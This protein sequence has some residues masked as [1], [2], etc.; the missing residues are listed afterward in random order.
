MPSGK[1]RRARGSVETFVTGMTPREATPR[2]M[3]QLAQQGDDTL[4]S[5]E[6]RL[7]HVASCGPLNAEQRANLT[8]AIT[9][10]QGLRV[11]LFD[12]AAMNGCAPRRRVKGPQ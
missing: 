7:H 12:L 4:T 10:T 1:A 8:F 11:F 6:R 3:E 5:I 9:A 2:E